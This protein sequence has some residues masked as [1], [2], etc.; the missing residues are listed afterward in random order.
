LYARTYDPLWRACVETGTVVNVHSGSGHPDYGKEP[1]AGFM[2]LIETG[3]FS[4][5]AFWQMVMGG[6][7]E[8]FPDLRLVLTEQ[9]CSWLPPLLNLLD[10]FH[11]QAAHGRIGELKFPAEDRLPMKPSEYFARNVYVGVSFPG[12]EEARGMRKLG[13]DRVMWGSDYPHHEGS[14]PF[15]RELMR[16]AFSEWATADVDQVLCRTAAQVYDFDLDALAP[17]A[18]RYGPLVSEIAEPLG[19]TPEGATSPGFYH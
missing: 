1:G 12:V 5:R 10:V 18:A 15:S 3:W 11:A 19:A 4:H 16:L 8:R 7:F 2:W 14:E 9:G 6:V 17:L 13:L